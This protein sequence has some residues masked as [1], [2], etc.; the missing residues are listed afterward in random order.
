VGEITSQD[1][2]I[3]PLYYEKRIAELE[4]RLTEIIYLVEDGLDITD[5][6]GPNLEMR[7]LTV[8]NGEDIP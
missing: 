2:R 7:I 4:R 5:N 6:G 8:A 3:A 1:A